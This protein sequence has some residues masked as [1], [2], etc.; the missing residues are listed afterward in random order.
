[1]ACMYAYESLIVLE[2][3]TSW[4]QGWAHAQ[5]LRRSLACCHWKDQ[6]SAE[7]EKNLYL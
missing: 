4:D 7:A 1:M 6:R 3:V 5:R 2:C